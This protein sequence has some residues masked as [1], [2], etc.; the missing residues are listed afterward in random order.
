MRVS[1]YIRTTVHMAVPVLVTGMESLNHAL[2]LANG[3]WH[4]GYML[5]P[6]MPNAAAGQREC[7]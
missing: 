1:D 6:R 7:A 4:G 2:S 5:A 3:G